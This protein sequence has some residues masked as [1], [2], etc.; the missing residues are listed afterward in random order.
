VLET[1]AATQ[2]HINLV[3]SLLRK[4][5][6]DLLVRGEVHDLS[7]FSPEEAEAF[8]E[9]TPRL[10]SSTYGSEEY[11]G[12]LRELGPALGHHYANNRHHPEFFTQDEIWKK[13]P[14]FSSY[15]VSNFGNVRSLDKTV[16][17]PGKAKYLKKGKVIVQNVTPKGYCRVQLQEGGRSKNFFVHVLVATVFIPNPE[18]RPE[19]NHIR[20]GEKTNNHV[21]NLEWVTTSRNLIHSYETGLREA[22][23]KYCVT[24]EETGVTTFGCDKMAEDLRAR[25]YVKA[26]AVGIWRCINHGGSHLDLH[27]TSERF[28][29]WM[30]SPVSRMNLLDLIEMFIDW[31]AS[32]RRHADGDIGRSIEVNRER[33]GMSD[34]LVRIFQNTARDFPA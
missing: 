5:A 28:E 30:N 23:V 16:G 24:C 4:A 20:G 26:R 1:N 34:Q 2:Q 21:E 14:G 22:T 12:F 11:K 6:V 25:G 13:V 17:P 32:S 9:V 33:F 3:R 27:F 31:V 15:E 19:V 7:K 29:T 8:A 10:R 18:G